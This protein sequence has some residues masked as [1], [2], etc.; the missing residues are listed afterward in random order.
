MTLA[1]AKLELRLIGR[2][3]E[4][5]AITIDEWHTA[6]HDVL[7]AF[8]HGRNARAAYSSA[9]TASAVP[10]PASA[11]QPVTS[12]VFVGHQVADAPWRN[13]VQGHAA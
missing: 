6:V 10:R 9:L 4:S 2:R 12:Q 1:D 7:A 8:Q 3:Y 5:G 11:P 13:H